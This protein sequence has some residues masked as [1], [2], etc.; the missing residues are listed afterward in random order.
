MRGCASALLRN[1]CKS[2]VFK[3]TQARHGYL[4]TPG[5]TATQPHRQPHSHTATQT[6]TQTNRH[7]DTHTDTQTHR[8]TDAQ[9]HR[10]TDTHTHTHTVS[11][12][13]NQYTSEAGG[14]EFAL[15]QLPEPENKFVPF[16][17]VCV[18]VCLFLVGDALSGV[19]RGRLSHF[20]VFQL[21]RQ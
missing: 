21:G 17:C 10:H 13:Y 4:L 6:A 3:N 8:H 9:T 14:S 15:R 1:F 11:H 12:V 18:C 7:T 5:E 20:V 2:E 19:G 16:V